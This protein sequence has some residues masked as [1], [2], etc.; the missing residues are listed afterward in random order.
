MPRQQGLYGVDWAI[1][2]RCGFPHPITMLTPQKGLLLCHDHGCFDNLDVEERPRIISDV[3]Q[4][5]EGIRERD[6]IFD[7]FEGGELSF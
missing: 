7:T 4:E 1:C 5:E 2:D 6:E 3:L